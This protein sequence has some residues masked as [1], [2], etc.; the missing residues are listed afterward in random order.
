MLDFYTGEGARWLVAGVEEELHWQ[1]QTSMD[2]LMA[3]LLSERD[4]PMAARD[5]FLSPSVD[6]L[7]DPFLIDGMR[8]TAERLVRAIREQAHVLIY[9]DYDVDGVTAVSILKLFFAEIRFPVSFY[10]PDRAD[11]GYG[12]SE[13]AVQ[14]IIDSEVDVL[15]TVDCGIT[16]GRQVRAITEGR[17]ARGKPIDVLITDHHQSSPDS[18]PQAYA[19]V[20]PHLP[21][22]SYP[23]KHLCGAGLAWKLVQAVSTL[24]GQPELAMRWIDLAAFATI[25]DIVALTGENRVLVAEGIARM[26]TAPNP[27]LAALHEVCGGKEGAIDVTRIG[28]AMAPRVNAAGR[29]GD[30][31][32]AVRLLTSKSL[33]AARA[34]AQELDQV[35]RDRQQEQETVLTQALAMLETR[36]VHTRDAITVV[37]GEGWHHGVIG[38]VASKLVDRFHKPAVVLS[39]SDGE[40]VGS[41]RSVDGFNLF[42]ALSAQA[43]RLRKFGGHAQAGGVTLA[44]DQLED[45]REA[46]NR[47]AAPLITEQM[48]MPALLAD[49]EL[50]GS[51]LTVETA[52]QLQA[53]EPTGQGNR[54]PLFVIRQLEI[55]EVRALSEGRHLRISGWKDGVPLTCIGFGHGALAE[56]LMPGDT[57]DVSGSLALN[58]WQGRVS[59]QFRLAG[60]RLAQPARGFNRFMLEAARQVE[61]LDCDEEW[62]YNGIVLSGQPREAFFPTREDLAAVYR[63]F[64]P[65]PEKICT[66]GEL[67][68]LARKLSG[69]SGGSLGFFRMMTGLMVFDE[70][71][72]LSVTLR[73]DGSYRF[74]Q[75]ETVE[76]VDLEIS[77]LLAF[78][79]EVAERMTQQARRTPVCTAANT[80]NPGH[81]AANT[82]NPSDAA[83]SAADTNTY[84]SGRIGVDL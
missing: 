30:A 35:N 52:R 16:A 32:R 78:L 29:M 5:V 11:E 26:N 21:D 45:F 6:H 22:A 27:G 65:F 4:V 25:A 79:R 81:A 1:P 2:D 24:L 3:T 56:H 53:L 14:R 51:L 36:E 12:I 64:R 72:L 39:V 48:R 34:L 44:A 49:A 43:E 83:T 17:A 73:P 18:L 37:W 77:E 46:L 74:G 13:A 67:F 9:G 31:K 15:L 76:K 50:G 8:E 10:I 19:L 7:H 58:E 61:S 69:P 70:L 63:Y 80:A 60:V 41:G 28:F 82:A 42:E 40:A 57:V 54:A 75:P 33:D 71:G 62:L 84:R 47:Y 20:D 59:V 68:L 66:P 23:F 38:I 55:A